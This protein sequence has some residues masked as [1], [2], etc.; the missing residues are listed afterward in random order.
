[1]KHLNGLSDRKQIKF[2]I[3]TGLIFLAIFTMLL[4][5]TVFAAGSDCAQRYTVKARD[6]MVD[7]A[8]LYNL[9]PKEI[10]KANGLSRPYTLTAGQ[11]LCIP[12][13]GVRNKNTTTN[14]SN[15]DST[16]SFSVTPLNKQFAI[17]SKGLPEKTTYF[18]TIV[19]SGS[20]TKVG[21]LR[22]G[23][24]T[25]IRATYSLPN[26]YQDTTYY[27]VCLKNATTN[28]ASCQRVTNAS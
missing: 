21:V 17:Q 9:N 4:P 14:T 3:R 1:M 10:A 26:D 13:N 2:R 8:N 6:Y 12:A 28:L 25:S 19:S 15:A 16:I 18:V 20:K 22:T 27:T 5:I 23:N 24:S 11:T 7:I